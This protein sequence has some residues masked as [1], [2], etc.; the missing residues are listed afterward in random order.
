MP[1]FRVPNH[2]SPLKDAPELAALLGIY[3]STFARIELSAIHL[4]ST[5]TG[6]SQSGAHLIMN[7]HI[8]FS[9]RI[10]L[11][12]ALAKV[13]TEHSRLGEIKALV[14]DIKHENGQR[15]LLAHGVYALDS[16]G[17]LFVISNATKPHATPKGYPANKKQLQAR[18]DRAEAILERLG[19]FH[20]E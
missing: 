19:D 7:Q 15:N 3:I 6:A 18:C 10:V 9:A 2:H 14:A 20:A 8:N 11:L 5:L 12:E 4:F 16:E 13:N 17:G 1:D